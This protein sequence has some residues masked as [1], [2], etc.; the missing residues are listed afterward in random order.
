M[1]GQGD[2]LPTPTWSGQPSRGLTHFHFQE[3]TG[4]GVGRGSMADSGAACL[5]EGG[6]LMGSLT[7]QALAQ[8]HLDHFCKSTWVRQLTQ[9]RAGAWEAP[10]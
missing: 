2:L 6:C 5:P 1:R 9:C 4:A 7:L 3:G 8:P 10:E